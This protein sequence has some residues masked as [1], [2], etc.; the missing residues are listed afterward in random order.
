MYVMEA[1]KDSQEIGAGIWG[2]LVTLLP[3]YN[4]TVV[5]HWGA[6]GKL[7]ELERSML[8]AAEALNL[9]RDPWRCLA[10]LLGYGIFALVLVLRLFQRKDVTV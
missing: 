4:S 9:P 3:H 6:P 7:S 5:I 8:Y 1:G 2:F 10:L